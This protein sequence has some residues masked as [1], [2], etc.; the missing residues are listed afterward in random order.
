MM[1]FELSNQAIRLQFT[2]NDSGL[3]LF[4]Y[5]GK[6]DGTKSNA[7]PGGILQLQVSGENWDAHHNNKYYL[8]NPGSRMA[9]RS[10]RFSETPE[11]TKLEITLEGGGLAATVHYQLFGELPSVRCWTSVTNES[12]APAGL[13]FVSS[14][15]YE[16]ISQARQW[17]KEGKVYLPH[18][19]W[20]G[21]LQWRSGTPDQFGLNQYVDTSLKRI[22]CGSNGTWSTGEYLPMGLYEEKSEG[23][24]YYWQIEHNGPWYWEISDWDRRLYLCLSGPTERENHWHK[25]LKPGEC[26]ETV[27]VCVGAVDSFD[28][29]MAAL[30]RYRR[31]IRRKNQD[32]EDLP[33]IF[34]DY[35][36]CLFGDATTEKLLPL[37][38]AAAEA[39][40]EYFCIDAGWYAD[41]AWWD[42][43]GEWLPSERRFPGGISQVTDA[44]KSKGMKL[45]LWLE[46]EVMG[47]HSPTLRQAKPDWFFNR[48]GRAVIDHGRY[49]LDFRNPE[50]RAFADEVIHRMVTEYGVEYIK[51][52]YN[53]NGGIGTELD[54]DSFG[55]GLLGHNRAYL[56][57]LDS[58]FERYPGLVIENCSSGGLRM[59]YAMLSRY[60]IQS[61]SDQTDYLKYA[62]I[63]A[64]AATACCPEQA[65]IWSY[66]LADGSREETIFN[67][68]NALLCRIHQSGHL[69][70]LS[71]ERFDLVK[72]GISLYRS[73]RSEIKTGVPFYPTGI[74]PSYS[75]PFLSYGLSCEGRTFLAVWQLDGPAEIRIPLEA[76]G[77]QQIYPSG[78]PVPYA[79]EEGMLRLTMEPKTAR[80]FEV[81]R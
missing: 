70:N 22:S 47:V 32:N 52:D 36:N 6:A 61:T 19:T 24:F 51:M 64:N 13:E 67:M 39:G 38:D 1:N 25:E 76:S 65:A 28:N 68:V 3:V 79:M 81:F 43:V 31:R 33:V 35:M 72:E 57:W 30:T 23:A 9:Y 16:G 45:G 4:P 69:A 62:I 27:P 41:G 80:L 8:T 49:Q 71:P 75:V 26:F 10:H 63:S 40:C 60:S 48:H 7:A 74:A 37:I 34:N 46:I 12:D 18:N 2:V 58:I 54:S 50:V 44:I 17:E 11:G 21:E 14:F 73:I 15:F 55:D 78:D 66:P 42:G 20:T 77:V 59:D 56:R 53:I 29:A 5:F